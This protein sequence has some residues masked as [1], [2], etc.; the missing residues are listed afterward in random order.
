MNQPWQLER[1]PLKNRS[2]SPCLPVRYGPVAHEGVT[3]PSRSVFAIQVVSPRPSGG[4]D[5]T[6]SRRSAD[7]TVRRT[8]S[9]R[10]AQTEAEHRRLAPDRPPDGALRRQL[11]LK[12]AVRSRDEERALPRRVPR[13]DL[14]ASVSWVRACRSLAKSPR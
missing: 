1:T 4:A 11:P 8:R 7:A 10:R 9:S 12:R 2:P 13:A 5:V 3:S 14:L 6:P